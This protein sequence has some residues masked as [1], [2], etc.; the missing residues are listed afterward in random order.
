M[1]QSF[2]HHTARDTAIPDQR[3]EWEPSPRRVRVM[4]NGKIIADS[5]RMYLMRQHGFLVVYYIPKEDVDQSVL[6]S[7]NHTTESPYKGRAE[8][9]NV[10]VGDRVAEAAAWH[11]PSPK[12]GSPDTSAYMSFDWHS[13]DAWFEEDEQAFVHARDPYL[14]CETLN[15]S[16]HLVVKLDGTVVAETRRPLILLETGL[17]SRYY[18]PKTDIRL[19]WCEPSDTF[20]LCPYK[21][22]ARYMHMRVNGKLHTDAVWLYDYPLPDICKVQGR[23]SFWNERA[24]LILDGEK[25]T[26]PE[27]HQPV[28]GSELLHPNRMFWM[29]PPP[30]TMKGTPLDKLQ[31][32][33]ALPNGRVEG[34][35]AGVMN[36]ATE[37][38]GGRFIQ[39][40]VA[41]PG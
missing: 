25:V 33:T 36:M 28:D 26:R 11:Y 15:S 16:R 22:R 7:S 14:R 40:I 32:T 21:G 30:A 5:R 27:S 13:M 41:P 35:P 20:T 37:R 8:Y 18:V 17:V 23:V 38:A 39:S 2:L 34:P 24:E 10:R 31:R 3:T 19:D 12:P 4:F 29:V 1:A 6:E 9:W